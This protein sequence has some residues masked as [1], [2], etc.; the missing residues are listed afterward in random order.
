MGVTDVE[1]ELS[2]VEFIAL[3]DGN[4]NLVLGVGNKVLGRNDLQSEDKR[5]SRSHCN[6][7]IKVSWLGV[8][9]SF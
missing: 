6:V 2:F 1:N 8:L 9:H 7:R 4:R 5:V 3:T